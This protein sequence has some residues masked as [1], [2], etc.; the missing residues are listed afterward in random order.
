MRRIFPPPPIMYIVDLVDVVD[1]SDV[2][3]VVYVANV[4]Y[5]ADVVDVQLIPYKR[6]LECTLVQWRLSIYP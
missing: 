3:D 2:V 6:Y 1:V 4:V 5:G